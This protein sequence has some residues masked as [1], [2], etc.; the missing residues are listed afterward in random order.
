M[1]PYHAYSPSGSAYAKAVF[2][3]YGRDEDYRALR[4]L[5][6]NVSGCIIIAR[7]GGGMN[8]GAVV[9]RAEANGA[10]AVLIYADGDRF[11]KN[12]FER[13]HV[14]RGGI[15]DPLSPGWSSGV[16]GGES[17]DLED[18]E[19][20]KRFPKI[21]S[22]PLSAE[23]AQTI[24]YSLGG[25]PVPQ[26]WASSMRSKLRLRHV[27]P[28]PT[29]LNF[30]YQVGWLVIMVMNDDVIDLLGFFSFL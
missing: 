15:G 13:G 4:A 28:G 26:E 23:T 20:L 10:V 19:V 12:G 8:R 24:L 2:V 16:D 5:G 25:E 29:L 6:V 18:S 30:T 9:E 27:G 22:M 21:P 1:R 11:N 14:M 7:K 3:N 17:L